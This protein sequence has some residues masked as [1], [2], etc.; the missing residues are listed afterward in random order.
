[1]RATIFRCS[2]ASAAGNSQSSASAAGPHQ[3]PLHRWQASISCG[4]VYWTAGS[5]HRAASSA[6]AFVCCCGERGQTSRQGQK[7]ADRPGPRSRT[8]AAGRRS[9]GC[10]PCDTR[11]KRLGRQSAPAAPRGSRPI[12]AAPSATPPPGLRAKLQESDHIAVCFCSIQCETNSLWLCTS[13]TSQRSRKLCKNH[14]GPQESPVKARG[15]LMPLSAIQSISRSHRSQSHLGVEL[16][17]LQPL[18]TSGRRFD[19]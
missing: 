2:S 16:P 15:M 19:G 13:I 10:C 14:E 8:A 17:L 5:A 1:M 18:D 12:A 6:Q 11:P 3:R 7:Q 4:Q 9:C